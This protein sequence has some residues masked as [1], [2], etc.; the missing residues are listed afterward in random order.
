MPLCSYSTIDTEVLMSK[1]IPTYKIEEPIECRFWERGANDTY[2]IICTNSSYFLRIYRAN[3]FPREANE[4]EAE[5]L[6]YL[7]SQGFPV[8][9]PIAKKS[10]GF[11]TEVGASEGVRYIM[12][13]AA[14]EGIEPDYQILDHC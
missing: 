11:I 5:L 9:Y 13:T 4:F 14:A 10:G 8:A 3:A 2:K 1:I 7:H 12:V 6:N